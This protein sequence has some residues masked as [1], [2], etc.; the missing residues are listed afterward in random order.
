MGGKKSQGRGN[1][2]IEKFL[3]HLYIHP[4]KSKHDI[5]FQQFKLKL[6]TISKCGK[7]YVK[8]KERERHL[9]G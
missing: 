9:P 5:R 8:K 7:N 1:Y 6:E 4:L 2:N 3:K